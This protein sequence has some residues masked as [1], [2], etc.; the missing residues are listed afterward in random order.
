MPY[1]ESSV[2]RTA[3]HVAADVCSTPRA[4]KMTD[5]ARITTGGHDKRIW[6]ARR[7]RGLKPA[8]FH[9]PPCDGASPLMDCARRSSSAR[10]HTMEY[11]AIRVLNTQM[12]S[13]KMPS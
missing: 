7:A 13:G 10:R 11:A 9:R 12:A 3:V 4:V 1:E 8:G 2:C 5:T 6:Y